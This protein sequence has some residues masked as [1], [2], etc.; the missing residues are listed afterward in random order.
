MSIGWLQ[1][2]PT[3]GGDADGVSGQITSDSGGGASA[4]VVV[5]CLK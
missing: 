1:A 4:E 2:M 5:L 3:I